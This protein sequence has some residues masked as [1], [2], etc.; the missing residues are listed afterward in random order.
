MADQQMAVIA[1]QTTRQESAL[2]Y[3]QMAYAVALRLSGDPQQAQLIARATIE[4]LMDD[5]DPVTN[6]TNLK[7]KVLSLVRAN[8]LCICG[9]PIGGASKWPDTTIHALPAN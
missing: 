9:G 1:E 7:M 3:L 6:S 5:R 2:D 8:F 4:K